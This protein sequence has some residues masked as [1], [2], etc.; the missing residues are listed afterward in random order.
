MKTKPQEERLETAIA[1][2]DARDCGGYF[3]STFNETLDYAVN[4]GSIFNHYVGSFKWFNKCFD[5]FDE[6]FRKL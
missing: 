2:R 4:Q 3:D 1:C 6:P 5:V